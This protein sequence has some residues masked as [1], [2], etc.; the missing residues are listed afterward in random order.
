MC[1]YAECHYTNCHGAKI[2]TSLTIWARHNKTF[3]AVILNSKLACVLAAKTLTISPQ[4]LNGSNKLECFEYIPRLHYFSL[5]LML[6][7]NKLESGF[8]TELLAQ[9]NVCG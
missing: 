5:A 7:S 3:T 4:L 2:L 1:S 8:L 9:S 6:S